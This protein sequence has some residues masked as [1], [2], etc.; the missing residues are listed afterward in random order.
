M[1]QRAALREQDQHIDD[2]TQVTSQ[3]HQYAVNM[4]QEINKQAE[5]TDDLDLQMD[6]TLAKMNFVQKKLAILLKTNDRSQ[7]C[8]ILMLTGVLMVLI[9]FVIYL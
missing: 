9:F 7:I 6:K 2:L 8:T 4:N 5:I 1:N 3:L